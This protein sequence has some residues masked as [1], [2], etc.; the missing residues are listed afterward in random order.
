MSCQ[1]CTQARLT[2]DERAMLSP[3]QLEYKAVM[4]DNLN[5]DLMEKKILHFK[6]KPPQAPEGKVFI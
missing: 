5:G 2:E 1:I 3:S 6:D 4:N